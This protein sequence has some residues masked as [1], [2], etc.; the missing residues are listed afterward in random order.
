LLRLLTA[1]GAN[2]CAI[3]DPNQA[4][5]GFRGAKREY[6]LRFRQDFP[7]AKTHFL[8]QNYRSTQN[9][10]RASTQVIAEAKDVSGSGF[11]ASGLKQ[12]AATLKPETK[13][14]KLFKLDIHL[15]PTEK[16]EAEYVAHQIEQMVGGTSSFSLNSNRVD[17]RVDD[18]APAIRP[19]NH[20]AVLYRLKTQS[21]ALIEAL[22]RSGMPYQVIGQKSLYEYK[23]VKGALA[24]LWLL[25]KGQSRLHLNQALTL[26]GSAAAVAVKDEDGRLALSEVEGMKDESNS[27]FVLRL[28]SLAKPSQRKKLEEAAKLLAQLETMRQTQPVAAQIEEIRRHFS[29]RLN[30]KQTERLQQLAQ[31]AA[32]FDTRLNDF[33]DVAALRDESDVYDPRAD[34]ITLMT[35]H[36]SKGLE[37]PVVFIVGCEEGL[38]PYQKTGTAYGAG[39]VGSV[40]PLSSSRHTRQTIPE[41]ATE[42]SPDLEEERRLFYVGM[43]RA[44]EKLILTRSK[45]R[46]LFGKWLNNAP[47]RFL[48]DIENILKELKRMPGKP[49]KPKPA[50]RQMKLF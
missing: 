39:G 49:R 2:L 33:L 27:S 38:L 12:E 19:F 44:Q 36:A 48:D 20:F 30:Q 15:A 43:T 47:S 4:I 21:L 23:E 5:Y 11:Q 34:R 25:R 13:N 46:F 10:V 8:T 6:F 41:N 17:D 32:A 28:S 14:R 1:G 26:G 16:A 3:G 35:L 37:F 42:I 50:G 29:A 22:D 18:S 40:P 9:I 24:Y 7:R 31:R 45:K